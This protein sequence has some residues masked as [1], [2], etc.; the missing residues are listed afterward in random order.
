[1][2]SFLERSL[3]IIIIIAVC[4]LIQILVGITWWKVILVSLFLI[5]ISWLKSDYKYRAAG[6]VLFWIVIVAWGYH[7][8]MVEIINSK[9]SLTN[10]IRH[11]TQV[12]NDYKEAENINPE[13]LLS[14]VALLNVL[15]HR[16]DSLGVLME[17]ALYAG[18]NEEA[19]RLLQEQMK[20]TKEIRVMKESIKEFEKESKEK[21][22]MIKVK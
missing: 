14:K 7:L 19:N 5:G 1:M 2:K 22:Q 11:R 13:M 12:N 6:K 10:E 18:N 21:Q 4:A 20:I 16:Q 3:A 17:D 15:N 9:F 8:I